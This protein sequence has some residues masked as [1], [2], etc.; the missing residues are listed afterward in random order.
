MWGCVPACVA[1][2]S[3]RVKAAVSAVSR[4]VVATCC[5]ATQITRPLVCTCRYIHR[6]LVMVNTSAVLYLARHHRAPPALA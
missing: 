3:A 1:V 6:C 5:V 4:L 2:A